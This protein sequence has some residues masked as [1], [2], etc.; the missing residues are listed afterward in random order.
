[1][2][3]CTLYIDEAGDLG[4]QRGSD[5]FVLA[6]VLI[7]KSDEPHIRETIKI[8][9]SKT[10]INEIHL[11][12][13][14]SFDKKAYAVSELSKCD[15]EYI[16]IIV[17]TNRLNIANLYNNYTEKP[18]ILSY[19][20][21]CRYLLERASWILRDSGRTADIV[22]SSRGTSRDADLISYIKNKLIP[23]DG[24]EISKHFEKVTAK[25]AASWDMLQLA[26]VCATSMFYMHQI[27]ALGHTTPCFAYRLYKHLYRYK[28]Q[29]L[30]KYGIKYYDDTMAP[31]KQYFI[32]NSFCKR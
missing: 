24:N 32:E 15:F 29:K 4:I 1:M 8:I 11:R 25:S 13:M 16:T 22:L 10:N 7:N 12:K 26:D 23:Y 6:G 17:D 2:S 27:N 30:I 5:W 18:S 31:G 19:N 3:S 21:V 14:Q 9:K 20:H 28:G